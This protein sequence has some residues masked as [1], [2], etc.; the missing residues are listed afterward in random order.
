MRLK[1][2]SVV[3][4]VAMFFPV[5]LFSSARADEAPTV[6]VSIVPIHSLVAGVM[7]G[8][9]SPHLLLPG[10]ASP[11]AYAL[12][13]SDARQ[14][15][16]ARVVFWV[17]EAL[18]TFLE[19]PLA[20]LAEKARV[21]ELM[22]T[23]ELIRLPLR[24]GGL[25]ESHA[26]DPANPKG[27]GPHDH[28]HNDH[29]HHK[30]IDAHIWLDPANARAIAAAVAATLIEVDPGNAARYTANAKAMGERLRALDSHLKNIL[31]PIKNKKYIVFHDA[32]QYLERRYGLG[33]AG[34][35]T[36]S[37][38]RSPSARRLIEIRERIL[39][40]NA[41]CV[42]I[43]PQFEPKLAQTVVENTGAQVAVLDPLGA[44][45]TPGKDAYFALME[46]LASALVRCLTRP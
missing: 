7:D 20:T 12:R 40:A 46:E 16:N 9:G 32:Y 36:V 18:E 39:S 4:V 44:R 42:F 10:G 14:L 43:E 41:A 13:P 25:W 11:H 27:T 26:D 38:G 33:A 29:H 34:A 3:L 2:L 21:V 22:E 1:Y 23:K 5:S 31:Q 35:I 37:P 45:L 28:H 8:V 19:R 17:G 6:V 15:A 30:G 24:S